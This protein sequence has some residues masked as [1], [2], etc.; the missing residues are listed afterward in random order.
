[1]ATL[2]WRDLVAEARTR[3]VV[4]GGVAFALLVLVVFNFAI[5]LRLDNAVDVAPGILWIGF[6]FAGMLG[7]GRTFAAERERGTL[8]GL[9]LAPIDRGAIYLARV[10]T[11]AV[12]MGIVEAVALPAFVALY[13]VTLA[14]GP[15][16][17]VVVLGT[18]GFSA[19]G[20]VVAAIAANTRAREVMLPLLLLPLAVP[21]LIASV[22]AT[23]LALGAHPVEEL[24]WLQLLAGFDVI[25][26]ATS[27]LVFEYVLEE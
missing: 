27:F 11:N 1:M 3:E 2:V 18:I 22:K 17:L 6:A 7:F 21:V 13:N 24:P 8:D 5:D 12:L 4:G 9:L 10:I 23:A 15:A 26:V 16:L 19:A 25:L 20:T 14:W